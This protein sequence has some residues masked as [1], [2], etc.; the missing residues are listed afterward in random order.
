M[1][2]GKPFPYDGMTMERGREYA[3]SFFDR[4]I[5][6]GVFVGDTMIGFIKLVMDEARNQACL[7][8]ILSMVEHKDKA[9]TNAL[10]AQAVRSC[11]EH[12]V[13]SWSTNTLT[14]AIK[15]ETAS[16]TSRK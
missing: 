9:P 11:A 16:A 12:K 3:D 8:H 2:Q 13:S 14:T 4:S 7:V 6:I 1:R 5:Y 10:I 15:R